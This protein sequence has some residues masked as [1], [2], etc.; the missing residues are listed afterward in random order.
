MN[1]N[2]SAFLNALFGSIEKGCIEIRLIEDRKA[3]AMVE[4]RWYPAAAD[5]LADLDRLRDVAKGR[6]AAI[7]YG[8][9][10]RRAM[11]VGK[12]EDVIDGHV[13]WSD[14]DIKNFPGGEAELRSRINAFP[15]APTIVVRS[16]HGVHCYWLLRENYAPEQLSKLARGIAKELGGDH[17]FDAARLLRLPETLNRKDPANPRPVE[18]ESLDETLVYN[19]SEIEEALTMVG[20]EPASESP[21]GP[22]PPS[23][24]GM[25]ERA[26]ELIARD[27]KLRDIFLGMGKLAKRKDG[28]KTDCSSSGYDFSFVQA[29]V[30]H[31]VRSEP[32]LVEALAARPDGVARQK[33]YDYIRRTVHRVLELVQRAESGEVEPPEL[34][35][36]V[37]EVRVYPSTPACYELVIRGKVMPVSSA[38][39]RSTNK[40][41]L[42]FLDTFHY[43]PVMPDK[44]EWPLVVNGWLSV[45]KKVELPPDATAEIAVREAIEQIVDDL[46]FGEHVLDL[47]RGKALK[48]DDTKAFKTA[49]VV[50]LLQEQGMARPANEVCRHMRALNYSNDSPSIDGKK[51]RVWRAP[52]NAS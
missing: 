18:I 19:A 37:D 32:E 38:V 2:V 40:F 4:R 52:W 30:N 12:A 14:F 41:Q 46:P 23:G 1:K 8:V 11:N 47:A 43:L 39:L 34:D 22:P 51:A 25:S 48:V 21:N 45:A 42:A 35:F 10:P 28:G 36:K 20:P 26:R 7:F 50:K 49:T 15:C 13:V 31:G 27:K 29:L 5:L 9:L 44:K 16:G 3:G 24:N 17:T 6:N 33:G